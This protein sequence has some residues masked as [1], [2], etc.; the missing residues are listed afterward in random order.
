MKNWR[1]PLSL[2]LLVLL[3]ACTSQPVVLADPE[4]V[5]QD[6]L[7][8]VQT[9]GHLLTPCQI[10]PLPDPGSSWTWLEILELMKQKDIEQNTCNE[11]FGIIKQWQGSEL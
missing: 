9:P 5:Y 4:I 7:I 8:P 3:T 6:K 2:C 10:T 1:V 11:R